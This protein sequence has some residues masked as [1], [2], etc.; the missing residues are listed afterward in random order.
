M[1]HVTRVFLELPSNIKTH[2]VN[3]G[4]SPHVF[5]LA[6]CSPQYFNTAI[7]SHWLTEQGLQIKQGKRKPGTMIMKLFI[8]LF[9]CRNINCV[10]YISIFASK[11]KICK[12][13]TSC[14]ISM[15]SKF[16]DPAN[17]K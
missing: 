9:I 4:S 7:L 5:H 14:A 10:I 11:Y 15:G 13:S 8:Q 1:C 3:G 12:Y 16:T 2:L 6:P 17:Y